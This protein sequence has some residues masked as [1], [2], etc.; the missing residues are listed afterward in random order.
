MFA[1]CKNNIG[2]F[3]L[4]D[5][6]GGYKGGEIASRIAVDTVSEMIIERISNIVLSQDP[7]YPIGKETVYDII[8]SVFSI[9][10]EKIKSQGIKNKDLD[11]MGTTIALALTTGSKHDN[12]NHVYIASLGDSRVYLV[13]N[14]IKKPSLNASKEWGNNSKATIHLRQLTREN[15]FFPENALQE[16]TGSKNHH[17]L[18][19][20]L[21]EYLGKS[22][23]VKGD[24]YGMIPFLDQIE[25]NEDDYLLLC[26]DG[27]TDMLDD[28]QICSTIIDCEKK[29]NFRANHY[30]RVL[31]D[32]ICESLINKANENGGK[33]NI[34]VILIRKG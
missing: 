5:G 6:I 1:Y 33:D 18:K 26:T 11:G 25:W 31:L 12:G 28:N 13:T 9:V 32:E 7:K 30:V 8:T 14:S 4:A 20:P 23:N 21:T 3:I 34:T 22:Y 27:L 19:S 2:L 29:I 17:P 10:N 16:A 24:K 15:N